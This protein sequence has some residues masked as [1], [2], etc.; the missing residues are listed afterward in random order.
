MI[1][2]KMLVIKIDTL[3]INNRDIYY[4]SFYSKKKN[5]SYLAIT[6]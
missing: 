4:K 3:I 2:I 6:K 5:D 1:V